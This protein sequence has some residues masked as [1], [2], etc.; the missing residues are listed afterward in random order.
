MTTD[1]PTIIRSVKEFFDAINWAIGQKENPTVH[2]S[3][4]SIWSGVT[5]DGRY[6]PDWGSKYSN[7]VGELLDRLD[8]HPDST[9]RIICGNPIYRQCELQAERKCLN[10]DSARKDLLKFQEM[11]KRWQGIWWKRKEKHH[12]KMVLVEPDICI[13][14]GRNF[15]DI[16]DDWGDLSFMFRDIELYDQL[17]AEW[18][19]LAYG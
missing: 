11:Q 19:S 8:Q 5:A 3:T 10:R 17:L 1:R 7:R 12:T 16:T 18:E 13:I 9:V 2:I 4:F 15:T 6:T 14:G